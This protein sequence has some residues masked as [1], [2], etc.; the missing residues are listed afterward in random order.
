MSYF[1]DIIIFEQY[2]HVL[3]CIR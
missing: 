1:P 3:M 2:K